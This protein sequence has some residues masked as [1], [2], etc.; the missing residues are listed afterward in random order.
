ME[1]RRYWAVVW[2]HL[3]LVLGLP[4]LGQGLDQLA[5]EAREAHAELGRVLGADD[6]VGDEGRV[7]AYEDAGAEG[8]AYRQRLVV[9]V[10]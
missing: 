9:A 5:D 7:V 3:P 10:A 6:M 8:D 4:L 1:L 2:R